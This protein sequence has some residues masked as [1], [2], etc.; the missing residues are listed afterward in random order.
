RNTDD[1]YN[2]NFILSNISVKG[3]GRGSDVTASELRT[4]Y[5]ISGDV[6]VA[7][8]DVTPEW[9]MNLN[10]KD[11]QFNPG[12][13]LP[14]PARFA[15]T[16]L[17]GSD[18]LE[19]MKIKELSQTASYRDSSMQSNFNV[20]STLGNFLFDMQLSSL[21]PLSGEDDLGYVDNLEVRISD[22]HSGLE[23]FL[24]EMVKNEEENVKLKKEGNE[25]VYRESGVRFEELF[26]EDDR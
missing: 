25:Y 24:E 9:D 5:N 4:D 26:G 6:L 10:A 21:R 22:L 23:M 11:I 7:E 13:D 1:I 17:A 8:E 16:F 15:I 18:I 14:G 2:M 19:E 3:L 20:D 12:G